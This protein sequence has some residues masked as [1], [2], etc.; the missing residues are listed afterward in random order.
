MK[1]NQ[2]MYVPYLRVSTRGQGL[3]LQGQMNV[4][5]KYVATCGGSIICEPYVDKVSGQYDEQ[6][7][8]GLNQAINYCKVTGATLI[9]Q[10]LDRLSRDLSDSARI[11]FKEGIKVYACDMTE[12][13]M[14][15]AVVFGVFAGIAQREREKIAGRVQ[16][17]VSILK[18]KHLP[19][20]AQLHAEG[21]DDEAEAYWLANKS[22][23]SRVTY[24]DWIRKGFKLGTPREFTADEAQRASAVRTESADNLRNRTACDAI[25]KYLENADNDR[26]LRA[27]AD[28][29]KAMKIMSPRGTADNPKYYGYKSIDNLCKRYGIER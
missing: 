17:G 3:G 24:Q 7:R 20:M 2:K 10:A 23:R 1:E 11:C 19:T 13:S 12:E 4:I 16:R 5:E 6:E 28:H 29:L 14:S 18:D 25:K 15:D 21:K 8:E 26:T 22:P 27:I 9:V